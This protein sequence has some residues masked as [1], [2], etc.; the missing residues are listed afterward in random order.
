[1]PTGRRAPVSTNDPFVSLR[2]DEQVFR[3]QREV[4]NPTRTVASP[5]PEKRSLRALV[6]AK[7]IVKATLQKIKQNGKKPKPKPK[8]N[9]TWG[10]KY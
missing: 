2:G 8:Y 6:E 10:Y 9:K 7:K 3:R 4:S 1:M 5:P